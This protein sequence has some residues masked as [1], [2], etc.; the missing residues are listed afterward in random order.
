M[1]AVTPSL[2]NAS[3]FL[4]LKFVFRNLAP[5]VPT[6]LGAQSPIILQRPFAVDATMQAATLIANVVFFR[7]R[8]KKRMRYAIRAD[9]AS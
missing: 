6:A 8:G 3:C 7:N 5:F 1:S 2:W 9:E 4:L